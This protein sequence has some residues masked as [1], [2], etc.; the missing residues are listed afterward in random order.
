[1]FAVQVGC[2]VSESK[3]SFNMSNP[4]VDLITACVTAWLVFYGTLLLTLDLWPFFTISFGTVVPVLLFIAV[5]WLRVPPPSSEV[6]NEI[7][8]PD[9]VNGPPENGQYFMRTVAHRGA[10]LDAPEN[11]ITAFRMVSNNL[12]SRTR[13]SHFFSDKFVGSCSIHLT[14]SSI[15]QVPS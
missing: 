14:F 9:P 1:M 10:P 4:I 3:L 11:S 13:V 15:L 8:G 6:V 7:L 5:W 2:G 12:P